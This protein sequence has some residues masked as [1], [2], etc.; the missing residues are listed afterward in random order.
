MQAYFYQEPG[1]FMN[2]ISHLKYFKET[3]QESRQSFRACLENVVS[4]NPLAKLGKIDIPS[5]IDSDLTIDYLEIP[6]KKKTKSTLIMTSGMHG[7]EAGAGAAI[8]RHFLDKI[9]NHYIDTNHTSI[10]L[11]HSINPYGFKYNRRVTENNVDLNRNFLKNRKG[12]QRF[13]E[14]YPKV[15][16]FLNPKEPADSSSLTAKLFLFKAFFTI[17]KMGIPAIKQASLQGQYHYPQGIYFGGTN[18][19]PIRKPLGKL[20]RNFAKKSPRVLLIDLHTGYGEKGKLHLFPSDPKKPRFKKYTEEIFQGY[21][22]DWASDD[23]FYTVTGDLCT[24][25]YK[26]LPKKTE[27]IPMV[28]EYGTLNS[29]NTL[30]AI[31]SMKRLIRENQGAQFGYK[32]HKERILITSEFLEMFYPSDPKWRIKIIQDTDKLWKTIL[33]RL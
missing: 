8:Q 1:Q 21:H 3:Y 25:F 24:Y 16:E 5:E 9:F 15:F 6:S 29:Q 2:L 30:G 31:E 18:Y 33:P 32:N 11:I 27:I 28:I 12:F 17:L 20:V 23:E 19:E 14:G 22:I 10:L 4:I 13:N 7:V 26:I